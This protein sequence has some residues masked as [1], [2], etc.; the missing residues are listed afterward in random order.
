MHRMSRGNYWQYEN[1][2]L[3]ASLATLAILQRIV[4]TMQLIQPLTVDPAIGSWSNHWQLIQPMAVDPAVGSWSSHWQLIQLLAADPAI[5]SWS[6]HWQLIQLLTVDPAIALLQSGTSSPFPHFL[7]PVNHKSFA[8]RASNFT[9]QFLDTICPLF[10]IPT[11]KRSWSFCCSQIIAEA[12]KQS[13]HL[14]H[15]ALPEVLLLLEV[16]HKAGAASDCRN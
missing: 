4:Q 14:L 9:R 12:T 7:L 6:S 8:L 16:D 10:F 3:G 13:W 1:N 2:T 5:G 11:T 15:P